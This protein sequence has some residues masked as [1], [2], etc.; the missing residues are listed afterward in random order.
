MSQDEPTGSPAPAGGLQAL[1]TRRLAIE[2]VIAS[3]VVLVQELTFIRWLPSQVR[4][5]AYYPNLVLLG[6]F[7]GLGLGCLL[8]RG[9]SWRPAWPLLT[10]GTVGAALL[11]SRVVFTQEGVSEHLFLLYY[12]LPREAP[13]FDGVWPPIVLFFL[14]TA[15]TFVPLG[16]FVAERLDEFRRRERPLRGYSWDLTGS[17]LGVIGFAILGLTGT[18]P[19]AWFAAFLLPSLLLVV[20]TPRWLALYG[21][22][23]AAILAAVHVSEKGERYSPYY[24][25]K[26]VEREAGPGYEILANGSL[27]QI[28]LPLHE[29]EPPDLFT[30]LARVGYL[31]PY[32]LLARPPGRVLVL[33]AGTGNDVAAALAMGAEHVDAVEIDPDILEMGRALHPSNPYS[34]PKV[35]VRNTDA[36]AFLNSTEETYDVVVLGTLDSMTRLSALSNVRLDNFVYTTDALRAVRRRLSE[37]GVIIMYFMVAT[38]YIDARLAGMV[39]EAFAEVPLIGGKHHRLFNRIYMAG[40]GFAH[41]NGEK[42]KA[43]VGDFLEGLKE[44]VELPTDDWP[45]LYLARRGIRPFYWGLAVVFGLVAVLG[46]AVI[47]PAMRRGLSGRAA[48]DWPMFWFGAGFLLIETRAVTEMNLLWSATWLTSAIVFAAILATILGAT[49]LAALRPVRYEWGTLG[50]VLALLVTWATPTAALLQVDWGAKLLVSILFVGL[51]AFFAALC[52]AAL[53]R[54]RP[55]STIAFGWNLLGA[56]AGGLLELS[57]MALGFKAVHLLAVAAYLIAYLLWRR[58]G[59][60]QNSAGRPAIA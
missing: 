35:H 60:A 32:R 13:V 8:A 34:S 6:A 57:T 19:I 26:A 23:G 24:V 5:L 52:F 48:A 36:R 9:L 12:D 2:L 45:Y 54:L 30:G 17:L 22:V 58:E 7:L 42:R 38:D 50:I 16:Q 28:A 37:R 21:I 20:R 56:V 27:H 14:L 11:L 15:A 39:A 51:P 33:G 40:P 1:S 53:F 31:S 43:E 49:L 44:K 47:S 59:R 29:E 25:L 4:V 41:A 46:V 10:L 3:F 55:D 18:F